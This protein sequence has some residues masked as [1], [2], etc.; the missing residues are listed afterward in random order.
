MVL[1]I[2]IFKGDTV[3]DVCQGDR[4]GDGTPDDQDAY[5]LNKE[6]TSTKMFV[7]FNQ[8][9]E[10]QFA[11]EDESS[12]TYKKF[13]PNWLSQGTSATETKNADASA[14]VGCQYCGNLNLEG[15]LRIN[16]K[17]DDDLVGFVFALQN[18]THYYLVDWK[19]ESKGT[20]SVR[21]VTIKR[22]Q[23]PINPLND[24]K[25]LLNKAL[26]S[27]E[28]ELV[29]LLWHDKNGTGWIGRKTYVCRI[30]HRPSTGLIRVQISHEGE[31]LIDSGEQYDTM[32]K[33]GRFGVY[34]LSQE[35]ATFW[36][37]KYTCGSIGEYALEFDGVSG[38]VSLPVGSHLGFEQDP[39]FSVT[40]WVKAYRSSG[41]HP[42]GCSQVDVGPCLF[43]NASQL[44]ARLDTNKIT[45]AQLFD[46]NEW[47]YVG[48][49][50]NSTSGMLALYRNG[51]L[52]GETSVNFTRST[53]DLFVGK[54]GRRLVYYRGQID[55]LR[56][57]SIALTSPQILEGAR[58]R[59]HSVE[60][61][62]LIA[63]YPVARGAGR[64]LADQTSNRLN[65]ILEG[66]IK[67]IHL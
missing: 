24:R 32:Y 67:W 49:V 33:G 2:R 14:L 37:L 28:G 29:Y 53:D 45:D 5:P 58:S 9:Q 56:I 21:G 12:K 66:G 17:Q 54:Y 23:S 48:M 42:I 11:Y 13:F 30:E 26:R 6:V 57:W 65:S 15:K 47:V 60:T 27:P 7:N 50:F 3:G 44:T 18:N 46:F 4:D 38:Y 63:H 36:D 52:V 19:K 43:I 62:R 39:S 31:V 40:T 64:V 41:I 16:T 59:H 61:S 1:C 25:K 8:S 51:E 34:D 10:V 22:V 20:D 55:E 35:M